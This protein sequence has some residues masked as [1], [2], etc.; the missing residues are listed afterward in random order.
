VSY[1]RSRHVTSSRLA[2][3]VGLAVAVAGVNLVAWIVAPVHSFSDTTFAQAP[4]TTAVIGYAMVFH[5]YFAATFA[6][7]AVAAHTVAQSGN[8]DPGRALG[9]KTIMASAILGVPTHVLYISQDT[10]QLAGYPATG[11]A[12]IA[13]VCTLVCMVGIGAGSIIFLA[14]PRLDQYRRARQLCREL[15]PLWLRVRQLYPD[16]ALPAT[17]HLNRSRALHA[18]RMLI[19]LGDAWRLLHICPAQ[20]ARTPPEQVADQLIHPAAGQNAG[21]SAAQLLP[22]AHSRGDEETTAVAVAR[23]Y[24]ARSE[25]AGAS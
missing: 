24:Q 19:E 22:T 13:G 4:V 6:N 11:W 16:V 18:E 10:A 7:I 1:L 5:L 23:A 21:M 2:S 14:V 3:Q 25:P 20:H 15:T 17:Q 8:H 12:T 9:G